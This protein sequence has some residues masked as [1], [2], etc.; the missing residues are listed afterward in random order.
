VRL[1]VESRDGQINAADTLEELISVTEL[2]LSPNA[3]A[4]NTSV[5][6]NSHKWRGDREA[7]ALISPITHSCI[8]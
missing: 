5:Y 2:S 4:T 6:P 7:A 1:Q 8:P 3:V